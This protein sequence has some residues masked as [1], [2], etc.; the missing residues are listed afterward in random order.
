MSNEMK[1][2]LNDRE[3]SR[4]FIFKDVTIEVDW[5]LQLIL[6]VQAKSTLSGNNKSF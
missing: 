4:C 1:C 2:S 3:V 6:K 5:A